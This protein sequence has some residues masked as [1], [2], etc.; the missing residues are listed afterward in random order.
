[1][2]KIR[3]NVPHKT[4]N[5]SNV[6]NVIKRRFDIFLIVRGAIPNCLK[7]VQSVERVTHNYIRRLLSKYHTPAQLDQ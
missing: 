1:M 5:A 6:Y 7:E 3:C 4:R 2:S